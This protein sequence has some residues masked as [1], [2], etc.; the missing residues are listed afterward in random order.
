MTRAQAAAKV[1]AAMVTTG[2][3]DEGPVAELTAEIRNLAAQ[4]VM[5]A[6]EAVIQDAMH[7]IEDGEA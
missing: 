5:L 3:I 7:G 6:A 2:E 4:S 1:D